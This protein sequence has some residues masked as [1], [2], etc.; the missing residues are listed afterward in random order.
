MAR[1]VE[2]DRVATAQTP[3]LLVGAYSRDGST[4]RF[5][6]EYGKVAARVWRDFLWTHPLA[7]VLQLARAHFIYYVYGATFF[8]G[9]HYEPQLMPRP[10]LVRW[11]GWMCAPLLLLGGLACYAVVL[12]AGLPLRFGAGRGHGA[13]GRLRLALA[14]GACGGAL[15]CNALSCCENARFFVSLTPLVLP[16]GIYAAWG[17]AQRR[18]T[19]SC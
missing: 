3:W 18:L 11:V 1:L 8:G 6:L 15:A 17:L 16:V 9:D 13:P 4:T 7:A 12:L 14:A 19:G 2:S 10:S 5:A